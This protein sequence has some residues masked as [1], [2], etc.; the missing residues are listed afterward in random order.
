MRYCAF[1]LGLFF[2]GYSCCVLLSTPTLAS[3]LEKSDAESTQ[4][5]QWN[6]N[7]KRILEADDPKLSLEGERGITP[8]VVPAFEAIGKAKTP[9]KAVPRMSL[10]SKLNPVNWAKGLWFKLRQLRARYRAWRL[11]R[12]IADKRGLGPA[13]LNGLTPL[14]VKNV[15]DETIRYSKFGPD[16]IN[17]IE[18]DYD[19]FV[20]LYFA[21]FDGLHKDP[22]IV[23][24]DILDKMVKEM[25]SI[26]RLAVRTSLDRVR[27]TVDA[28]YSFE[29]LISLDVSPLLYMRLLDAE[30]AFSDVDKNRDAINHLKGYVKAYYKHITL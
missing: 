15:K 1:R 28:G 27:L 21:Q 12:I 26:E 13:L 30:G 24:M 19:S 29:K 6:S 14:H 3:S 9:E 20:K 2:I 17:Q 25:S 5:E 22:P 23:K 7:G 10:R 11:R 8:E 4:T 18:K 16:A